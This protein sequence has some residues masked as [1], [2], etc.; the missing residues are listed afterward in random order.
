MNCKRCDK[1]G[2][3][4]KSLVRNTPDCPCCENCQARNLF[5][6]LDLP[7]PPELLD[8]HTKHP[9]LSQWQYRKEMLKPVKSR[10]RKKGA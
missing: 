3:P 5:D 7:T 9:T 10:R 8:K 2:G 1:P 6:G 4:F